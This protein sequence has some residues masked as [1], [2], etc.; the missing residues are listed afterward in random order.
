MPL[1]RQRAKSYRAAFRVEQNRAA[2]EAL[3]NENPDLYR[4]MLEQASGSDVEE[5]ARQDPDAFVALLIAEMR[6]AGVID[7]SPD[8]SEGETRGAA[9]TPEALEVS[10][11]EVSAPEAPHRRAL[12][13]DVGSTE[14]GG[15]GFEEGERP[16]SRTLFEGDPAQYQIV[17]GQLGGG[18]TAH[19]V[20][21]VARGIY[22]QLITP[23][24]DDKLVKNH[25]QWLNDTFEFG[26][27]LCESE[28]WDDLDQTEL[29]QRIDDGLREVIREKDTRDPS[30]LIG[31]PEYRIRNV[32]YGVT[33]SLPYFNRLAEYLESLGAFDRI[34]RFG[35][36]MLSNL[37]ASGTMKARDAKK[38]DSPLRM[39]YMFGVSLGLLDQLGQLSATVPPRV[40]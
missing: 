32:C 24:L 7:T 30:L 19:L 36:F 38:L 14:A 26:F 31:D 34:S 23:L 12:A 15:R 13:P 8:T 39:S 1:F 17:A 35:D 18:A 33:A 10:A 28:T 29:E 3:R 2:A 20:P 40:P 9:E 37:A 5:A 22:W 4:Q 27:V 11:P 21:D 25:S 6:D 16:L